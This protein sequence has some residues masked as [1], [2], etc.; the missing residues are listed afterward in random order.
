MPSTREIEAG[1]AYVRLGTKDAALIS[2]LARAQARLMA[3]GSH[4]RNW[5]LGITAVGV[6]A[7]SPFAMASRIFAKTGDDVAKMAKRTGLA[8]TTVSK[9]SYAAS[10]SGTSMED[11]EKAIRS[12]QRNLVYAGQGLTTYTRLLDALG[13]TYDQL[14]DLSPEDQ[15]KVITDRLSKVE[16]ATQ[17]AGL[18]AMFFGRAGTALLPMLGSI[19]KLMDDAARLGLVMT[20]E[21]AKSAEDLTDAMDRLWKTLKMA[22][23]QVGAALAPAM[24]DLAETVRSVARTVMDWIR[25]HREVIVI[26]AKVA[27]GIVA[28]G[29]AMVVTGTAIQ[30]FAWGMGVAITVAKAAMAAFAVMSTVIAAIAS[31]IG[32]IITAVVSLGAY[33]LW[34]SG[35]GAKVASWIADRFNDLKADVTEAVGAMANAIAAG[36]IGAAA[37][38]LWALL[39]LEWQ[40]GI[41][42]LESL[43]LAFKNGFI[44]LFY[45]VKHAVLSAWETMQDA[46]VKG[47]IEVTSAIER[48]WVKFESSRRSAVESLAGWMAKRWLEAK[49]LFDDSFDVNAAKD[50]VDQQVSSAKAAI[51]SQRK[52]DLASV[53]ERRSAMRKLEEQQHN[54]E[55][56]ANDAER[57]KAIADLQNRH[58]RSIADSED[59][60]RKA[61]ADY[62]A[63]VEAA[64]GLRPGTGGA[65]A[66]S[67]SMPDIGTVQDIS[68]KSSAVGTFNAAAIRGMFGGDTADRTAKATEQTA[69]HTKEL[70][71]LLRQ[72][73][74]DGQRFA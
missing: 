55:V 40:K 58:D 60:L 31:P 6:A 72:M 5:G 11:M 33:L 12:M 9:L 59:A 35:A 4:I 62:R 74:E 23:F 20:E 18:A 43:W 61:A 24:M 34:I 64:R 38:V 45:D 57:S 30:A 49:G 51:D 2:G 50:S 63:A 46:L 1:R 15:F 48:I 54:A 53:E 65:S 32:L 13:L 44:A 28:V 67:P 29:V 7:L 26:A 8:V 37:K 22:A 47:T 73:I 42:W 69:A 68:S 36:D 16:N 71:R 39:K 21:D 10:Q 70:G 56:N 27:V 14:K 3:F 66:R 25:T 52:S 17:R 19:G 41:N